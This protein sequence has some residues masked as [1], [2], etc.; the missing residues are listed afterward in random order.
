[1]SKTESATLKAPKQLALGFAGTG[2]IG[3]NRMEV[4]LASEKAKAT[5][6]LEP[7]KDNLDAALQKAGNAFPAQDFASLCANADI[8]GIVIATP[9]AMHAQQSLSA[10]LSGK[11]VFCQKPLGRTE[12]EVSTIIA[13]SQKADKYLYVDLS[14]RHTKAFEAIFDSIQSGSLGK[15]FAVNLV[16][17]NAY[18][19]D[20]DWFYDI[21]QSGGGCV[22][23]LGTHLIDM[24]LYCLGFPEITAVQSHLFSKGRQL[25]PNEPVVEDFAFAALETANGTAIRLECS[26]NV[27]AG[28]DA[29]IVANFFGTEGG[30]AF[31]N[32]NGS[33]YEFAA[34][35]YSGTKTETLFSGTDEWSGR[36]GI[37]WAEEV[38]GGKGHDEDSCIEF[39]K[40]AR[41]IDRIYGR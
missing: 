14:Y 36:A 39:L 18:G 22:I 1:M 8:D 10:L 12:A 33:F 32:I 24:A 23:D 25:E 3:R 21:A 41:I 31:K 6:L 27:S 19:P 26:W 7:D 2:W 4:L 34:E 28:Q 16:F 30:A 35:K 11:H 20:K 37:A 38:L 29:V 40:T 9:S 17:H 15:I 5:I 13:A